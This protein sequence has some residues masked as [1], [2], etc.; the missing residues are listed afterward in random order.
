MPV[1]LLQILCI[2]DVKPI[3]NTTNETDVCLDSFLFDSFLGRSKL[4]CFYHCLVI[5]VVMNVQLRDWLDLSLNHSVP[6]SLLIRV[7][8]LSS[9]RS[10]YG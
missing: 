10:P 6:S 9:N 4:S 2:P 3:C 5:Q 1:R 7:P 8:K